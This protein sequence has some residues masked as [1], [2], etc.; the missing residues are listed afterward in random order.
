[1]FQILLSFMSEFDLTSFL[2]WSTVTGISMLIFG[3]SYCRYLKRNRLI[4]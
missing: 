3:F 1:M 2:M 4:S